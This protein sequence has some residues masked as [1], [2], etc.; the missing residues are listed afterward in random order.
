M[1][2]ETI[3][4]PSGTGRR[5]VANSFYVLLAEGASKL[6]T[7]ALF[8]VMV[9][10]LGPAGYGVFTFA[11]TL[12]ALIM[13]VG[14][15]GQDQV[16]TRQVAPA[17]ARLHDYFGDTLAIKAVLATPTVVVALTVIALTS[18]PTM[19]Q[20][21]TW[22]SIGGLAELV[23]ST[24]LAS[25]QAYE[26][27][28]FAPIVRVLQRSLI[29]LVGIPLLLS[30]AGVVALAAVYTAGSC[31]AALLSLALLQR[32]NPI[33]FNFTPST[34]PRLIR[35]SLPVGLAGVL[36]SALFRLDIPLLSFFESSAVVGEYGAAYRL[37]DTTL[38]ISFAVGTAAYPLF[39]R[40]TPDSEPKVGLVF[41]MSMKLLLA[42]TLPMAVAIEV[43]ADSIVRT[44]FG[45]GYADSLGVLQLLAPTVVLF[46]VVLLAGYLLIGRNHAAAVT[47]IYAVGTAANLALNLI[48]I[49]ILSL[50]G[51]ALNTSVCELGLAAALLSVA[52]SETHGVS[53]S[54]VI[55]GPAAAS[56]AMGLLLWLMR[57]HL[58]AGVF[59]GGVAYLVTLLAIERL[60]FPGDLAVLRGFLAVRRSP[61]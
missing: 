22:I 33:R 43:L 4:G 56:G 41:K 17:P 5:L 44:F 49:P 45:A 20:V 47:K 1:L 7:L 32:I 46:P 27:L 37:L 19:T 3:P 34:W 8:F 55:L 61:P 40:L 50:Y 23:T 10:R 11:I 29:V 25:Y 58:L 53:W 16:L 2:P 51:A 57:G 36:A 31:F 18:S 26:R 38:F 24:S 59:A 42:I 13:T 14:H 15:F 12:S 52:R 39:C 6:I 60:A 35:L 48:L 54:R 30:G 28:E 9:R 21:L